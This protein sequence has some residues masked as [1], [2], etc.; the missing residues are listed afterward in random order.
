M[1][2][3]TSKEDVLLHYWIV[4]NTPYNILIKG[5]T[6]YPE[7]KRKKNSEKYNFSF[8]SFNDLINHKDFI[9][10]WKLTKKET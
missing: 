6:N 4:Y 8:N 1:L 5:N 7:G 2:F 3:D 10:N 9:I